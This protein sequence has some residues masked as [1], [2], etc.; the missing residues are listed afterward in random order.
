MTLT[1]EAREAVR[2]EPCPATVLVVDDD[3]QAL[4]ALQRAL[5]GE[6]YEARFMDDPFEALEWV[7]Q[8][9][10]HLLITDEFMPGM[11]GTELLEAVRQRLPDTAVI[12]LTGYPNMSVSYRG[13]QQRVDLLMV[14]PWDDADLRLQARRLLREGGR[15]LPEPGGPASSGA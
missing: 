10:I 15:D 13:F 9:D 12:L 6:P 1:Q 4:A 7:R 2:P 3:L 11:L 8:R 5:R 14:K